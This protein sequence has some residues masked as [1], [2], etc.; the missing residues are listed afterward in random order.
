M[1]EEAK[2]NL[3]SQL[4]EFYEYSVE[5]QPIITYEEFE[6]LSDAE[7]LKYVFEY[8]DS[9]KFE[10]SGK[11][12]KGIVQLPSMDLSGQDLS[13]VFIS[14]FTTMSNWNFSEINAY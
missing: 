14:D 5:K 3:Y 6:K 9:N 12:V 11:A 1:N 2:R 13:N 7:I 10:I 4:E 8:R